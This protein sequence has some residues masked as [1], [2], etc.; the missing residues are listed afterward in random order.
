MAQESNFLDLEEKFNDLASPG[1]RPGLARLAKLLSLLGSPERDFPAIHIVGT[2]GKGSSAAY[3]TSILNKAGYKT[4]LYTSPHLVSF[5]E[6]LRMNDVEVPVNTW[7]KAF[8]DIT[9]AIKNCPTLSTDAP[10]YFELITAAAFLIISESKVDAAVVEAGLGG[11][12]DAT[13]ILKNVVLTLITPIGIDHSEYLGDTVESIAA[14]KFAVM[15]KDT[16]A[17]FAGGEESVEELFLKTAHGVSAKAHILRSIC[18]HEMLDLSPE[19]TDF[20]IG[21]KQ[22]RE[23]FRTPLIGRHQTENAALAIAGAAALKD[24]FPNITSSSIRSG[25]ASTRWAGRMELISTNPMIFLDGA[26]NPHAMKRLTETLSVIAEKGAFSVVLAMMKDKD[27]IST[28]SLLKQMDPLV[29]CT[30]IPGMERS[31]KAE[32]LSAAAKQAGL[33]TAE[34]MPEPLTALDS[35]LAANSTVICCGSLF[36]VGYLK[37]KTASDSLSDGGE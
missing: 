24:I 26:H 19:G 22:M 1:I 28:L 8:N 5:G 9:S 29:F 27:I 18:E 20:Y 35:A 21:N 30:E 36:L 4:A 13:N 15:R 3:I 11:R 32:D 33:R 6:R 12:L 7:N 10:T 17:I 16:P 14:E 34:S 25:I 2:N 23:Y 37:S 31:M